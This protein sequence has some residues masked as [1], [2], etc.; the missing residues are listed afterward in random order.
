MRE[1]LIIEPGRV[2]RRDAATPT[3]TTSTD[4]IV[5]PVAVATC[6][7]GRLIPTGRGPRLGRLAPRRPARPVTTEIA[8]FDDEPRMLANPTMKPVLTRAPL[9]SRTA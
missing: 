5:R 1:P 4:A 9:G 8:S 2:E 3:P 7:L 6:D